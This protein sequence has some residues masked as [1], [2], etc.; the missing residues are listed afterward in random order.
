M[1]EKLAKAHPLGLDRVASSKQ[2]NPALR[3]TKVGVSADGRPLM[4][5]R[6]ARKC[7]KAG[8]DKQIA[9]CSQSALS[10]RAIQFRFQRFCYGV[11]ATFQCSF[12]PCHVNAS[13]QVGGV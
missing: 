1:L 11:S 9:P 10:S 5:I 2:V 13:F 12:R 6:I 8:V 3:L 7:F 4:V